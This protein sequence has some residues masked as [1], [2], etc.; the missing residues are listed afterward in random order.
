MSKKK[1]SSAIKNAQDFSSRRINDIS[2]VDDANDPRPNS[3][4]VCWNRRT[5]D[6][7]PHSLNFKGKKFHICRQPQ[8]YALLY[9]DI[10]SYHMYVLSTHN[11]VRWTRPGNSYIPIFHIYILTGR[12]SNNMEVKVAIF[13][14]KKK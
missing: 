5:V 2:K 3:C 9:H 13:R 4:L 12:K 11:F 6:F 14:E 7:R 1:S 8:G 10:Y